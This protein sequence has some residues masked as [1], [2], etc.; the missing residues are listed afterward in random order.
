MTVH[1]FVC[2]YFMTIVTSVPPYIKGRSIKTPFYSVCSLLLVGGDTHPILDPANGRITASDL[3]IRIELGYTAQGTAPHC[4]KLSEDTI[5]AILGD[6]ILYVGL[7]Y[8]AMDG[9]GPFHW[10]I[11]EDEDVMGQDYIIYKGERREIDFSVM[12][13]ALFM[14]SLKIAGKGGLPK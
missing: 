12:E 7:M 9:Y 4:R 8:G 1:V 14:F 13:E 10:E 3:R 2:G 5:E 6:K 11:V